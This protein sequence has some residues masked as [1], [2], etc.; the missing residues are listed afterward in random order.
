MSVEYEGCF[1]VNI[2]I[3]SLY[4]SKSYF[5]R[6][7]LSS[8]LFAFPRGRNSIDF[9]GD[10]SLKWSRGFVCC[11]LINSVAFPDSGLVVMSDQVTI[12]PP[13]SHLLCLPHWK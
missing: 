5:A 12:F 3:T 2:S 11:D 1:F 4:T 10:G 13:V 8:R 9:L 7:P 6:I